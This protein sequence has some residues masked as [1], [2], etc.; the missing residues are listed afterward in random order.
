MLKAEGF[1]MSSK[2]KEVSP[3][4]LLERLRNAKTLDDVF[5]LFEGLLSLI[6]GIINK[7]DVDAST[8]TQAIYHLGLLSG[9]FYLLL[10]AYEVAVEHDFSYRDEL[11]D[12][13]EDVV[14]KLIEVYANL[15]KGGSLRKAIDAISWT[16][17][18]AEN[19]VKDFMN[20]LAR[21]I[22]DLSPRPYY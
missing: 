5:Y 21:M 12:E 8:R 3:E 10:D 17:V 19:R 2:D 16:S 18:S 1:S 13:I 11:H 7:A 14:K 4:A 9:R 15:K 20:Y 6:M 22:E